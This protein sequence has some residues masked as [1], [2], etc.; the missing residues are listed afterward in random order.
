MN[1]DSK[2]GTAVKI[3][4][5][6]AFAGAI[7]TSCVQ[8]KDCDLLTEKQKKELREGTAS[9]KTQKEF[10]DCDVTIPVDPCA[11]ERAARDEAAANQIIYDD[12]VRGAIGPAANGIEGNLWSSFADYWG[13]SYDPT[14][15]TI[16]DTVYGM[17]YGIRLLWKDYGDP[18]PINGAEIQILYDYCGVD[19]VGY[20]D[21]QTKEGDLDECEKLDVWEPTPTFICNKQGYWQATQ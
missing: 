12:N 7:L 6:V 3:T 20:D 19:S 21:L 13:A 16:I 4:V 17:R 14:N 2:F 15:Y 10:E 5:I 11:D 8:K 1:W 18:F 9:K